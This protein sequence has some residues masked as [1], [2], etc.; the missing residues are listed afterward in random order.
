MKKAA[1]FEMSWLPNKDQFLPKG[2]LPKNNS[3][4]K[5]VSETVCCVDNPE[6]ASAGEVRD[7]LAQMLREGAQ[8]MLQAAM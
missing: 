7:M 3:N 1:F 8:K 2:T 5:F 6:R 4:Q